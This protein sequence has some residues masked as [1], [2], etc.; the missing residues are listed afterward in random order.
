MLDQLKRLMKEVRESIEDKEKMYDVF[1]KKYAIYTKELFDIKETYQCHYKLRSEIDNVK[2]DILQLKH[3]L[4]LQIPEKVQ[5]NKS[6]LKGSL[7]TLEKLVKAYEVHDL[8]EMD[9]VR[10]YVHVERVS[11]KNKVEHYVGFQ[12]VDQEQI[13]LEGCISTKKSYEDE[14]SDIILSQIVEEV[15]KDYRLIILKGNMV[16]MNVSE[17]EVRNQV[18]L[19]TGRN[20]KVMYLASLNNPQEALKTLIERAKEHKKKG[21]E[22]IGTE[23]AGTTI[24]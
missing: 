10:V 19:L 8:A 15:P 11:I 23:E 9:K 21:V 20:I 24:R 13:I 7:N 2:Q 4:L 1:L 16:R 17:N 6:F 18:E 3:S 22:L 14:L 5:V 12:A